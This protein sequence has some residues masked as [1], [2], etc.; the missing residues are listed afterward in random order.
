MRH[1]LAKNCD[2]KLVRSFSPGR[3]QAQRAYRA[4]LH[5]L[6][7]N[8]TKL[9]S[10]RVADDPLNTIGVKLNVDLPPFVHGADVQFAAVQTDLPRTVDLARHGVASQMRQYKIPVP[11]TLF[12]RGAVTAAGMSQ[13]GISGHPW[14]AI[15]VRILFSLEAVFPVDAILKL[16]DSLALAGFAPRL[17]QP[18][19]AFDDPVLLRTVGIVP[20]HLHAQSNQPQSQHRWQIAPRSPGSAVVDAQPFGYAPLGKSQP[21]M[22]LNRSRWHT[23]EMAIGKKRPFLERLRCTRP[24]CVTT[25]SSCRWPDV[26]ARP[27]RLATLDARGRSDPDVKRKDALREQVTVL[28]HATIVAASV[29]REVRDWDTV[30]STPTTIVR[31][32]TW[33]AAG[34]VLPCDGESWQSRLS[35]GRRRLHTK[36]PT[37]ARRA[38]GVREASDEWCVG[39]PAFP[40]R[41][42]RRTA[43]PGNG[44]KWLSEQL[45]EGRVAWST[46][47]QRVEQKDPKLHPSYHLNRLADKHHVAISDKRY[48]PISDKLISQ[49]TDNLHVA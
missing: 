15:D 44:S 23:R 3:L 13:V 39:T 49:L 19:A 22:L 47:F 38:R 12:P 6:G 18:L 16:S 24:P 48:V 17:C 35:G 4:C 9:L 41:S 14:Q 29:G 20:M 42:A 40:G 46:P 33:D 25:K 1:R 36:P 10:L 45:K 34:G 30:I 2:M 7:G 43:Q 21:E 28:L 32:P 26:S 8:G 37:P 5:L 27:H 31:H 11:V